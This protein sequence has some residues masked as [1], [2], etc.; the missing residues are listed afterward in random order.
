MLPNTYVINCLQFPQHF[1]SECLQIRVSKYIP[2]QGG[3][4]PKMSQFSNFGPYLLG[5]I[6]GS[7]PAAMWL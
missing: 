3:K 2:V 1:K 4:K 5:N 7:A 6:K